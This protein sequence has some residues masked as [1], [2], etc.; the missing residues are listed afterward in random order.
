MSEELVVIEKANIPA[1]FING[2]C[3]PV[4]KRIKE[5]AAKFVPDLATE[6]GR[7]AIGSFAHKIARSKTYIDGLGKDLVADIK[8]QVKVVDAE[9]KKVRDE[10]DALKESVRRP[11]TEWENVEKERIENI[12]TWI[13]EIVTMGEVEYK[14]LTD[15]QATINELKAI[16]VDEP[17]DGTY[18]ELAGLAV[19]KISTAITNLSASYIVRKKEEDDTAEAERLEDERIEKE[20]I[21]REKKIAEEAAQKAKEAAEEKARKHTEEKDRLAKDAIAKAEA[22]RLA[23]KLAADKSER[24][25]KEAAAKAIKDAEEAKIKAEKDKADAIQAEKDRQ[26]AAAKAEKD[27]EAKRE[28]DKE[29]RERILI[30]IIQD[31]FNHVQKEGY[32]EPMLKDIATAIVAGK[33]RHVKVVF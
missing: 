25:K 30:H 6:P 8:Q 9:R 27:A 28:A 26:A 16:K 13:Q 10:L 17:I 21:E 12:K 19:C 29:H 20:R 2:G 14:S 5:E 15:I 1:L 33:I 23:A 3:D 22:G 7:K 32:T 4:L 24:D 18:G 31:L 11:L